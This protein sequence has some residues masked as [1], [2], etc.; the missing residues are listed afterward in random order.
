MEDDYKKFMRQLL[1]S[2]EG[3][4]EVIESSLLFV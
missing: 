4:L 2:W 1:L 3:T